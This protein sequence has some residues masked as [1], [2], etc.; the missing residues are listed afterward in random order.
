MSFKYEVDFENDHIHAKA[1][2]CKSN[3]KEKALCHE[4]KI[5]EVND[6]NRISVLPGKVYQDFQVK[7]VN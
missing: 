5:A 2:N 3:Q 7:H 1:K 6:Q 4:F